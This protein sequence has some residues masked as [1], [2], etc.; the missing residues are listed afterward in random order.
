MG[1]AVQVVPPV[2]RAFQWK[3][4]WW[5]TPHTVQPEAFFQVCSQDCGM[6][7]QGAIWQDEA[8]EP[9]SKTRQWPERK[10]AGVGGSVPDA[11]AGGLVPSAPA[12]G[13]VLSAPSVASSSTGPAG[14]ASPVVP[15]RALASKRG[16]VLIR[17]VAAWQQVRN[18]D[19]LVQVGHVMKNHYFGNRDGRDPEVQEQVLGTVQMQEC[20]RNA[21]NIIRRQFSQKPQSTIRVVIES[22]CGRHRSIAFGQVLGVE[23]SEFAHVEIRH[24]CV[25]RWDPSY[26]AVADDPTPAPRNC[27]HLKPEIRD[28]T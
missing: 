17:T 5:S 23:C 10:G 7:V 3:P 14:Y 2:A 24:T 9:V 12:V 21:K 4:V 25:H 28:G 13:P 8:L 27:L 16:T 22:M 18:C 6:G 15:P 26:P 20:L 11:L 19:L 1:R